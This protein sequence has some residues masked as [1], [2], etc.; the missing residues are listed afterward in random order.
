MLGPR[1]AFRFRRAVVTLLVLFPAVLYAQSVVRMENVIL[2]AHE[3]PA[4]WRL[5][6]GEPTSEVLTRIVEVQLETELSSVWTQKFDAGGDLVEIEYLGGIDE[7]AMAKAYGEILLRKRAQA[8]CHKGRFVIGIKAPRPA[9]IHAALAALEP[10]PLDRIKLQD[11]DLPVGER[12][13]SEVYANRFQREALAK[14]LGLMPAAVL[15]QFFD[16]PAPRQITYLACASLD[17]ASQAHERT[18]AMADGRN[19]VLREGPFVA[20]IAGDAGWTE[21]VH[22]AIEGN[23]KRVAEA[24]AERL[25]REQETLAAATPTNTPT[26]LRQLQ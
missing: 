21:R 20:E 16:G 17:D 11:V 19:P 24:E 2:Q 7:D 10:H 26:Q 18:K 3:I 4:G 1:H 8:V 13:K 14:H 15:N 9:L 25:R 22:P 6:S 5:V 23:L 12:I